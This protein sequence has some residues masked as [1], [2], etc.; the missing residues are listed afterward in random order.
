MTSN[1]LRQPLI[2]AGIVL[3]IG[4][5]GFVDGILFHQILQVHQMLSAKYPKIGVDPQTAIANIEINMFWDGLFHAFTWL[6]T[7]LGVALLWQAVRLKKVP[8][9]TTTLVGSLLC[10]WGLFNLVEG[11]IDHHLLHIHHVT[12]TDGHL[13]WDLAFLT[14]GVILILIGW[15]L[16]HAARGDQVA[17]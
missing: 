8:L 10:G 12:E 11:I 2:T 16:I 9:S 17:R 3:G 7:V 4:L 6:M 1:P 13:L 14:S 15:G 5:G